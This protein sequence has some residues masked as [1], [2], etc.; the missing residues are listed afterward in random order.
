MNQITHWID[1]SNVYGSSKHELDLL[2]SKKDGLLKVAKEN[3]EMLP[4]CNE[5]PSM[6][7]ELEACHGP[8]DKK[9][10]N[11]NTKGTCFGAGD[12]RINEHHGL[13]GMHTIWMREHN[14]VA[15]ELKRINVE[16]WSLGKAIS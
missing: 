12:M 1:A 7:D 15:K 13:T 6:E 2:R 9:I 10:G 4:K 5:N 3:D 16:E 14:R 11:P 8:C